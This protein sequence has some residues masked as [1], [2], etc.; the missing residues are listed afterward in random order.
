MILL[1]ILLKPEF[2][3]T[4]H[5][6]SSWTWVLIVPFP[7]LLNGASIILEKNFLMKFFLWQSLP[8]SHPCPGLNRNPYGLF[9]KPKL[10]GGGQICPPSYMAIERYF[11][12]L[13]VKGQNPKAQPSTLKIVALRIFWKIINFGKNPKM[14]EFCYLEIRL[15]IQKRPAKI[16]PRQVGCCGFL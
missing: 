13:D 10:M 6:L 11:L 5:S 9:N 16:K 4:A 12:V 2:R 15:F 8:N 7:H 1:L 3:V 14:L